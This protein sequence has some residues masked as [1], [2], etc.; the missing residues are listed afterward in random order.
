[1]WGLGYFLALV[2]FPS[3]CL[4]RSVRPGSVSLILGI[5]KKGPPS[6][7]SCTPFPSP[8][9]TA[10]SKVIERRHTPGA[11]SPTW[12]REWV[13]RKVSSF[14]KDPTVAQ[15]QSPTGGPR[16]PLGY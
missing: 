16:R 7:F 11:H 3:L 2:L 4:R 15:G 5:D 10:V 9:P 8:L 12:E 6:L 1:M 13:K 14:A